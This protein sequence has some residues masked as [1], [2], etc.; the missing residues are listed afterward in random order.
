VTAMNDF[1][2]IAPT[3]L[4]IRCMTHILIFLRV[5]TYNPPKSIERHRQ[6]VGLCAAIFAGANLAESI[7]IFNNFSE[8]VTNVEPYLPVIMMMVLIFVTWSGGNIARMIPRKILERL[9]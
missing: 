5:V 4:A 9:P 3:L 2:L 7:R 8:Y 6:V 1:A